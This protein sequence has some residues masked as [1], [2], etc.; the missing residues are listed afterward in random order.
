MVN[1]LTGVDLHACVEGITAKHN[2]QL[3]QATA[4]A[5]NKGSSANAGRR[6]RGGEG[7]GGDEGKMTEQLTSL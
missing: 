2:H 5:M 7:G 3:Q 6:G 1:G 4:T